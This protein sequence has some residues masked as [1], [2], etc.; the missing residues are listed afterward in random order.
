M[1]D[2]FELCKEKI[3][4]TAEIGINHNGDL[5]LA[6]EMID[7]AAQSG[8]DAVKF[9][10]FK[11]ESMYSRLT[12]GFQHTDS[13]VFAQMKGLEIKDQWWPRLKER[14]IK[15]GL[16]FSASVFDDPS[17]ELL[18]P[19]GVDFLKVASAE[20]INHAFLEKQKELSDIY[21][22]STGMS[23]L[24]EVAGV[25]KFL[26][27]IGIQ[28]I[29]LL[30]CTSSYPAPPESVKLLNID[31]LRDTFNLP[32]G[33]SD[34]TLGIH[35]AMAAAA[36]GARFIEKHFTLDKTMEGPDQKISTDPQDMTELVKALREI[37]RSMASNQKQAISDHEKNSYELG[38][39]SV[40]AS[41]K[42]NKGEAITAKNIIVKRP[43]NGIP[44]NEAPYLYGRTANQ[45][46]EAE[47]WITWDMVNSEQ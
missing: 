16:L 42:I 11:T 43:G 47:Q 18:K 34:H 7:A 40:I 14:T 28:K 39:K 29:I 31:Y 35:Y 2:I 24:E 41:K 19:I 33:F 9:Q 30:E 21:V 1:K 46:I 3:I 4:V 15:H 22:I 32:A 13:D 44:P 10:A 12:P 5:K 20:I 36:R 8:V 38:R 6:E 25:V 45:E 37:E 17:L 23:V 26:N 27:G